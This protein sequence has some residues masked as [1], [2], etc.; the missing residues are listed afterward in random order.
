MEFQYKPMEEASELTILV[1]PEE[2]VATLEENQVA[3]QNYL[4]SK[5]ISF[6]KGKFTD[7][8]NKLM[9]VDRAIT[10]WLDVQ[11]HWTHLRPIFIGSEDIKKQLPEQSKLFADLDGQ[12]KEFIDKQQ[13]NK[14]V[15]DTCNQKPSILKFLEMV[16]RELTLIEKSLNEYL[17]TKRRAF[18][19]FYFVSSNDLLDILS[20]GRNPRDIEPHFAKVYDNLVKVNWEDNSAGTVV[21]MISRENEVVPFDQPLVLEGAVEIWLQTLLDTMKST[22]KEGLSEAVA[23]AYDT[24]QRPDWILNNIGQIGLTATNIQW[25]KEVNTAFKQL[26]EGI[27]N[28]MKDY[29]A[30]QSKQLEDLIERIRSEHLIHLIGG[31][32]RLFVRMMHTTEMLFID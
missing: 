24:A 23:S 15:I 2:L 5:N 3:V 10:T 29:N 6:F 12:M 16:L 28:A 1:V 22:L 27:E 19:R 21:A 26:E 7:W 4:S 32:L 25:N 20:K 17:E 30:K 8:Q 13:A 9:A 11:Y 14:N 18:P 31:T